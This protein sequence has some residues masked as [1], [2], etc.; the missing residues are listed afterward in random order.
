MGL[1]NNKGDFWQF[2]KLLGLSRA[3]YF[4]SRSLLESLKIFEFLIGLSLS[5]YPLKGPYY[6]DVHVSSG[7]GV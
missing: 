2:Y 3:K 5:M 4:I 6:R 1:C 7:E